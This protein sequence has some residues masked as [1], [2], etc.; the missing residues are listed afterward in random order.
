MQLSKGDLSNMI[1]KAIK[2]LVSN[3]S[4]V[5]CIKAYSGAVPIMDAYDRD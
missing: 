1:L 4:T 3:F 2:G 5:R